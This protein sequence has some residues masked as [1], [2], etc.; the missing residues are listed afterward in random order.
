MYLHLR[1]EIAQATVKESLRMML[2]NTLNL[3]VLTR[4]SCAGVSGCLAHPVIVSHI[5]GMTKRLLP[6]FN[7]ETENAQRCHILCVRRETDD[8]MAL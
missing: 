1:K 8:G 6:W 2:A 7:P 4:T 5:R 3:T